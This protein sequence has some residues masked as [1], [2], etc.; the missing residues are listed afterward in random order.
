LKQEL[1]PWLRLAS[2]RSFGARER[3]GLASTWPGSD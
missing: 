3:L 1:E 2:G